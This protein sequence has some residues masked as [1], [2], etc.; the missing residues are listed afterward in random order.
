MNM[1][2]YM[3]TCIKNAICR[4]LI[5]SITIKLAVVYIKKMGVVSWHIFIIMGW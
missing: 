3:V 4:D 1:T 2:Q 5:N